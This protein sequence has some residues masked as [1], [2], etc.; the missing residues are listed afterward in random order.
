M[1]RR[2]TTK[3]EDRAFLTRRLA[4]ITASWKVGDRCLAYKGQEV[5]TVASIDGAIV[6]LANGDSLHFSHMRRAQ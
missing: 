4:E 5:T 1:A 3:A 6:T 2:N